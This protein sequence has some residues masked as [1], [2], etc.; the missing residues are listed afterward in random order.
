LISQDIVPEEKK[1]K[2]ELDL[3]FRL[4][5]SLNFPS[6]NM[7]YNYVGEF[8]DEIVDEYYYYYGGNTNSNWRMI[9]T[10]IVKNDWTDDL[11]VRNVKFDILLSVTE[12]LNIGFGYSFT[13]GR[14]INPNEPN[15]IPNTER[16]YFIRGFNR[17]PTFITL[18]PI[19]EY[20]FP[21]WKGLEI[22]PSI[23]AGSYQ[24]AG[25]LEGPGREFYID[26]RVALEYVLW[27]EF[28]FRAYMAYNQWGYRES[29]S[30]QIF[31]DQE[32]TVKTDWNAFYGGIGVSYRFKLRPD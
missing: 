27:E 10:T 14:R 30:S 5:H 13:Y 17:F 31:R 2:R 18:G 29:E 19:I 8:A 28:G 15:Q 3:T 23:F 11:N 7:D 6:V 20:E 26:G 32:R 4:D 21:I 12:R 24:S 22:T 9:D 1:E 16:P 25:G